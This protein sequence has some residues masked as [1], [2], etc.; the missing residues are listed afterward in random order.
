MY[1]NDRAL[2]KSFELNLY[3]QTRHGNEILNQRV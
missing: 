1:T 3:Q 2:N